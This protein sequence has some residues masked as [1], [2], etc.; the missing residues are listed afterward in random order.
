MG[1]ALEKMALQEGIDVT[2]ARTAGCACGAVQVRID[3]DPVCNACGAPVLIRHPS[4]GLTDV[5]AGNVRGLDYAP[6]IHVHYGEKVMSV[7]DGLPKFAGMPDPDGSGE[8][9]PE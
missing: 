5:P 1:L 3:G 8:Q 2:E 4:M 6:T 7:K 9:L